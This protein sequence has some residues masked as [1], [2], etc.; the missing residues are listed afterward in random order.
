MLSLW[1]GRSSTSRGMI[2]HMTQDTT[3]GKNSLYKQ[4]FEGM[5]HYDVD[6]MSPAETRD[7]VSVLGELDQFVEEEFRRIL[8][9]SLRQLAQI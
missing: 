7:Y 5:G 9:Q 4:M 3:H 1:L 6:G 8:S 2:Y